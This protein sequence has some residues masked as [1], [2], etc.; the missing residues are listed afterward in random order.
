MGINGDVGAKAARSP[1]PGWTS[2]GGHRPR[3]PAQGHEAVA[4]VRAR[5]P[6]AGGRR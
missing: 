3:P 1:R 5:T 2:G 4:A 6:G